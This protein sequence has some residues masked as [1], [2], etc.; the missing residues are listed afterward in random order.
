MIQKF[1]HKPQEITALRFYN[2]NEE[3][4]EF[5]K[6]NNKTYNRNYEWRSFLLSNTT[7]LE[8]RRPTIYD[9][10]EY[11]KIKVYRGDYIVVDKNGIISRMCEED[12]EEFYDEVDS[13]VGETEYV[14]FIGYPSYITNFLDNVNRVFGYDRYEYYYHNDPNPIMEIFD[15]VTGGNIKL[16]KGDTLTIDKDGNLS[17]KKENNNDYSN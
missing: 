5:L 2:N 13:S 15:T 7:L 10:W 17:K 9:A 12:I 14:T 4:E 16:M 8:I 3:V 6:E 11:E 1:V